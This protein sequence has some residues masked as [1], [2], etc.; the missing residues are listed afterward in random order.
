MWWHKYPA[1][2]TVLSG[3]TDMATDPSAT[4]FGFLRQFHELLARRVSIEY[5]GSQPKPLLLNRHEQNYE[6]DLKIQLDAIS[7]TDNSAEIIGN[8]LPASETGDN[9]W[10]Y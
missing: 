5:K 6:N 7:H 9:G 4:T 2:F 10:N 3:S 8:S 1:D